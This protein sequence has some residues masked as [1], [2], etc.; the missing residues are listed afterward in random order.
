MPQNKNQAITMRQFNELNKSIQDL[1]KETSKRKAIDVG[2]RV[3]NEVM[4]VFIPDNAAWQEK[5]VDGDDALDKVIPANKLPNQ[6]AETWFVQHP[7]LG[8]ERVVLEHFNVKNASFES[9]FYALNKSSTKAR[10]SAG[11]HLSKNW[12]NSELT[13][14]VNYKVG[15]NFFLSGD[16]KR[17]LIVLSNRGNLR[18]MELSE[19]LT[20]TQIEIFNKL[21]GVCELEAA[22]TTDDGI[23]KLI[24]TT[25]W[26]AFALHELNKK[27][28]DGV[29]VH[30]EILLQHLTG[31]KSG[32]KDPEDAKLFVSRLLGRLLFIWFL[33][34][35]KYRL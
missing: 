2:I 11:V 21:Y 10:V 28:Y 20:H 34:K 22:G 12:E 4:K 16:A 17:V 15:I 26:D 35:K 1:R 3:A 19:H 32:S 6:K 25:L 13:Q 9:R 5:L 8:G 24:H 33:R 30:F 29:A 23:Q 31:K 27:F 14:N 18:V 7:Y